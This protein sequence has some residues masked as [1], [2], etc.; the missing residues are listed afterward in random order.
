MGCDERSSLIKQLGMAS[1]EEHW[2]ADVLSTWSFSR[3][4]SDLPAPHQLSGS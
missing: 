3:K 1:S 4:H 2:V